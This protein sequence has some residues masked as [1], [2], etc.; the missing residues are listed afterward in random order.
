[1]EVKAY[2]KNR[3]VMVPGN[4]LS[5]DFSFLVPR[6]LSGVA[7]LVLIGLFP[8]SFISAEEEFGEGV[9][10]FTDLA[11]ESNLKT[12]PAQRVA[13]VDLNGDG[14][15][16]C[17]LRSKTTRLFLNR[18]TS[19]SPR[20]EEHTE[21]S[22][23]DSDGSEDKER[24]ANVLIFADIDNDG[25]SDAF[26][27]IYSDIHNPKWKGDPTIASAIFLND[28][29]GVFEKKTDSGVDSHPATTCAATFLD[30][31]NDGC[32][33]LFVG[34]W[35]KQYGA[36]L[37]ACT[38]RLYR[39]LGNG[40]F[41][42]VTE[43]MGMATPEQ[44]GNRRAA[45][46]VYGAGCCD[47]NNDGFQ[48]ILVC[49]YGRQWNV[50][51]ENRKGKRFVDAAERTG[52]DG[53]AID[54]GRYPA[55]LNDYLKESGRPARNDEAPFRSNGNTFSVACSDYDC[56]GDIDLFLG[57]ITHGWAGESSDLTSLLINRGPKSGFAF[58]RRPDAAP[59]KHADPDRWN[60][61]DMHVAWLDFDNDGF[62]DLL[63]SSGDYPDG[64]HLRLFRQKSGHVFEDVTEACGFDWESSSGISI[65]DYDR[66]GDLDILAGKSWMRMPK[67][68]RLGEFPAPALFRNDLGSRNHWITVQLRGKG[69]GRANG[70]AI[71]ARVIVEAGGRR[72][73]REIRGGCGHAGQ[74]DPPEA[75][76]GLAASSTIDTLV[77]QWP[78]GKE[79]TTRIRNV[80]ADRLIRIKWD[81]KVET[82][83][84][85]SPEN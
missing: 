69:K 85:N 32:I 9:K 53:D 4:P 23:L 34:N 82:P 12:A 15:L 38:S 58:L 24:K 11:L 27:G 30:F 25:D 52:F 5:P 67:E 26:S 3:T 39:G 59:R 50:L 62:L 78:D 19:A 22:R 80:K 17:V 74:F 13:F 56:D 31:D 6:I 44:P 20:F 84:V 16:D 48:D 36:S 76:F 47:Y 77:V 51:W 49:A 21:R 42:D 57:E 64:Q 54:H 65:G 35:Y 83:V 72:Q 10:W 18:G 28:G 63:I 7:T 33:D 37:E 40:R 60:Q 29:K 2:M 1:M 79:R 41:E 43:K 14:W 75:H 70:F 71:G 73:I 81:G 61:G 68:R 55:W 66:D 8:A 45:R 46:P